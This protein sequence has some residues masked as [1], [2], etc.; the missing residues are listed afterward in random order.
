[1]TEVFI[2]L[3]RYC[4]PCS[5]TTTLKACC[6]VNANFLTFGVTGLCDKVIDDSMEKNTVVQTRF[7]V[8]NHIFSGYRC[9][10]LKQLNDD[11]AFFTVCKMRLDIT[12]FHLDDGITSVGWHH[13]RILGNGSVSPQFRVKAN[14]SPEWFI[15]LR[16]NTRERQEW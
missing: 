16:C 13:W 2:M 14:T 15:C 9:P 8:L 1:M 10:L 4:F 5:A 7:D 6:G 12:H 3:K 11:R